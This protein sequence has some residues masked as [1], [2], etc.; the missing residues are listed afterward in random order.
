MTQ[1]ENKMSNA[2]LDKKAKTVSAFDK[3]AAAVGA[4]KD[5]RNQV[6][7]LDLR[8][9]SGNWVTGLMTGESEITFIP[10]K[11]KNKGKK[12]TCTLYKLT[13]NET[14][15]PGVEAT[16]DVAISVDG[17]LLGYQ[18]T[19]GEGLPK[20]LKYPYDVAIRYAG[21]DDEGRHQTEVRFPKAK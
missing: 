15:I 7:F 18:L 16:D 21:K 20:G 13:V 2:T 19:E 4:V 5:E 3:A 6:P 1:K 8:G 10:K 14:N 17:G 9:K 12:Q 11:G